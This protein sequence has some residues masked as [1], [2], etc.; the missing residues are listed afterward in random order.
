MGESIKLDELNPTKKIRLPSQTQKYG[1]ITINNSTLDE[2]H[3]STVFGIAEPK[4]VITFNGCIFTKITKI[5]DPN[6]LNIHELLL[7]SCEIDDLESLLHQKLTSLNLIG[8]IVRG[9]RNLDLSLAPNLQELMIESCRDLSIKFSELNRIL[10][11]ISVADQDHEIYFPETSFSYVAHLDLSNVESVSPKILNN[12]PNLV[13][14][15]YFDNYLDDS[16]FE[17]IKPM[18]KLKDLR[19][20]GDNLSKLPLIDN[21]SSLER[22]FVEGSSFEDYSALSKYT[23]VIE[24]SLSNSIL[25]YVD[26]GRVFENFKELKTVW[27]NDSLLVNVPDLSHNKKLEEIDLS[28][29]LIFSLDMLLW[30]LE[31]PN[32]KSIKLDKNIFSINLFA[33][34]NSSLD[35]FKEILVFYKNFKSDNK[36]TLYLQLQERN[37][38]YLESLTVENWIMSRFD[39]AIK[40]INKIDVKTDELKDIEVEKLNEV[41]GRFIEFFWNWKIKIMEAVSIGVSTT[42]QI[43]QMHEIEDDVRIMQIHDKIDDFIFNRMETFPNFK[44]YKELVKSFL[45]NKENNEELK[46]KIA[47]IEKNLF[48]IEPA[49]IAKV[50]RELNKY[51]INSSLL[52]FDEITDYIYEISDNA[53]TPS[54]KKRDSGK[55]PQKKVSF[56]LDIADQLDLIRKFDY[57]EEYIKIEEDLIEELQDMENSDGNDVQEETTLEKQKGF[58]EKSEY[59]ED[60]VEFVDSDGIYE[61]DADIENNDNDVPDIDEIDEDDVD[62]DDFDDED[63]DEDDDDYE[64][65]EDDEG[66]DEDASVDLNPYAF[67]SSINAF[68]K[69][70][71]YEN[72]T[73]SKIWDLTNEQSIFDKFKQETVKMGKYIKSSDENPEEYEN[74]RTEFIKYLLYHNY[75][76]NTGKTEK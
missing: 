21:S 39:P 59:D 61:Y 2:K 41:F 11:Y 56:E 53:F 37:G 25:I 28:E 35:I 44:K 75:C 7:V 34:I 1:E 17:F 9:N 45:L 3:L 16:N 63:Y 43:E 24:L 12:F 32:L 26:F 15:Y 46:Q 40:L 70:L 62:L 20:S 38:D 58:S 55:I 13:S 6:F 29:N 54:K 52:E 72:F 57:N 27:L 67:Y 50:R 18:T 49:I 19:I 36:K 76:K 31:T 4:A 33:L 65:E 22:L 68:P 73:F 71:K 66:L 5:T 8:V 47:V 48:I 10:R 30:V 74:I 69:P 23:K 51:C 42:D 14:L 64:D 60:D